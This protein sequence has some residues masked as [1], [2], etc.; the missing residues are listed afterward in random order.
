MIRYEAS[1]FRDEKRRLYE[2]V[3]SFIES[4]SIVVYLPYKVKIITITKMAFLG[5][6]QSGPE[7]FYVGP[8]AP[9]V[10]ILAGMHDLH[11]RCVTSHA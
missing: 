10:G 1:I 11:V 8:S 3:R 2:Q 9:P 5:Q 4:I 6:V 7:R